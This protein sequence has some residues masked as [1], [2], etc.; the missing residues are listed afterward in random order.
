MHLKSCSILKITSKNNLMCPFQ[1]AICRNK[2]RFIPWLCIWNLTK[3]NTFSKSVAHW[4]LTYAYIRLD[5]VSVVIF[6][7]QRYQSLLVIYTSGMCWLT[8]T[9][10]RESFFGKAHIVS[11]SYSRHLNYHYFS[12]M[13]RILQVGSTLNRGYY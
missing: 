1:Q 6:N 11:G 5:F 12:S 7:Q 2:Y 13:L 8:I 10:C 4:T 9:L 3:R